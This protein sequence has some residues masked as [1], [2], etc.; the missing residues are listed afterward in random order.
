M[1]WIWIEA[2]AAMILLWVSGQ[3]FIVWRDTILADHDTRVSCA[4]VFWGLL[5]VSLTLFGFSYNSNAVIHKDGAPMADIELGT[6]KV[7]HVYHAGDR[8]SVLIEKPESDGQ[9]HLYLCQF[10]LKDIDGLVPGWGLE[11]NMTS[12]PRAKW[13]IVQNIRKN[14]ASSAW[15]NSKTF[16]LTE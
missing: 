2:I 1:D 3:F 4:I 8:L 11:R 5:I 10:E 9:D 13:L 12:R 15:H 14:M 16:T 6:Y 7:A